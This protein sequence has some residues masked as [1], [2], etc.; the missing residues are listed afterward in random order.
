[1]YAQQALS[2][3]L[4]LNLSQ[5]TTTGSTGGVVDLSPSAS[6]GKRSMKVVVVGGGVTG[7]SPVF[8]LTLSECNTTNGTFTAVDTNNLITNVTT[9]GATEYHM[10]F[11]KR[12]VI[13]TVGTVTGTTPVANIVVL[14]QSQSRSA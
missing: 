5:G 11:T 13:A 10:L 6:I 2:M 8:P 3:R 4:L 14:A 1:M 7:T 9:N 12:Y